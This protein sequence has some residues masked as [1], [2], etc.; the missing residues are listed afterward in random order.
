MNRV[1]CSLTCTPVGRYGERL[2]GATLFWTLH[3]EARCSGSDVGAEGRLAQ[4]SVDT[5]IELVI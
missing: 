5:L 1:P 4:T 3:L 2:T